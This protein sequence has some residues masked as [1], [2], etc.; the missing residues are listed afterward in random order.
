M[1]FHLFSHSLDVQLTVG[2]QSD[3]GIDGS[4]GFV[5]DVNVEFDG[6]CYDEIRIQKTVGTNGIHET[7]EAAFNELVTVFRVNSSQNR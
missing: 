1:L 4:W 3:V 6:D 5:A 7:E 2:S